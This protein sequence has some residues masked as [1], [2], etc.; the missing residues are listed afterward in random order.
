MTVA[1]GACCAAPFSWSAHPLSPSIGPSFRDADCRR[2]PD[3]PGA[4]PLAKHAMTRLHPE[5]LPE[6][7]PTPV[8]PGVGL[9]RALS[10]VARRGSRLLWWSYTTRAS[11]PSHRASGLCR[12]LFCL[13]DVFSLSQLSARSL[14]YLPHAPP[15]PASHLPLETCVCV[16]VFACIASHH[17]A[18]I[19]LIRLL[20]VPRVFTLAAPRAAFPCCCVSLLGRLTSLPVLCFCSFALCVAVVRRLTSPRVCCRA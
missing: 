12:V 19:T 3:F 8:A 13:C 1:I 9:L 7:H 20:Y 17:T 5:V 15:H 14:R 18:F 2:S 4:Q 16:R 10:T 6:T 11:W